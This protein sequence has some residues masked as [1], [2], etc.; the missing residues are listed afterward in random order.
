MHTELT[1]CLQL[2]RQ[3]TGKYD[4]KNFDS[5]YPVEVV[6]FYQELRILF[7]FSALTLLVGRQEERLAC[8]K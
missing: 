7:F 3:T 5:L 4:A 6:G 1:L 8:K 2:Y